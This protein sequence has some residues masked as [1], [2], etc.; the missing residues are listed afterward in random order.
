MVGA[1]RPEVPLANGAARAVSSEVPVE[2]EPEELL[3]P[4]PEGLAQS[5]PAAVAA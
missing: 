3:E 2:W 5:G 4:R 1:V